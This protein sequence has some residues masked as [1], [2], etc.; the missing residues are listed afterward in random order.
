MESDKFHHHWADGDRHCRDRLD[1]APVC[2]PSAGRKT[3]PNRLLVFIAV[4]KLLKASM[5]VVVGVAGVLLPSPRLSAIADQVLVVLHP[6]GQGVHRALR[7][8]AGLERGTEQ[9]LALLILMYAVMFIVEGIGLLY[10]RRWAEWLSIVAT[11]SFV[12]F[13]LDAFVS[14]RRIT[15]ASMLVLNVVIVVYL[16]YRRLRERLAPRRGRS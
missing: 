15:S 1:H 11:G 2:V 8:L 4:L 7:W 3:L 6:G 16:V 12:P 14:H 9:W 5:L 10:G 13:E